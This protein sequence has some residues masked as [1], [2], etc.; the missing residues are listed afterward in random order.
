MFGIT[1][2]VVKNLLASASL[3]SHGDLSQTQKG[4][5][6]EWKLVVKSRAQH[7]A[8]KLKMTASQHFFGLFEG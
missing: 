2:E 6:N 3:K 8:G 7:T 5:L 4:F 1:I